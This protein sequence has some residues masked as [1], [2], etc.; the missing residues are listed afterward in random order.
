MKV[1][2]VIACARAIAKILETFYCYKNVL[3]SAYVSE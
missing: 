1:K 2:K 3:E